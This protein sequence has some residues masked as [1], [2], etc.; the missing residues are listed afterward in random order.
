MINYI[1]DWLHAERPGK[2]QEHYE[3]AKALGA[4]IDI[5]AWRL[6]ITARKRTRILRKPPRPQSVP[7]PCGAYGEPATRSTRTRSRQDHHRPDYNYYNKNLRPTSPRRLRH[8]QPTTP[9][10]RN[11]KHGASNTTAWPTDKRNP[12]IIAA[13]MKY[14]HNKHEPKLKRGTIVDG[15]YSAVIAL[16]RYDTPDPVPV[17]K[18]AVVQMIK[19]VI[20]LETPPPKKR[21]P[22]NEPELQKLANIARLT[23]TYVPTRNFTAMCLARKGIMR[24]AE[25]A[26]LR[27][28]DVWIDTYKGEGVEEQEVAWI[29]VEKRKND[30]KREG[31][32]ILLG[33]GKHPGTCPIAWIKKFIK[34]RRQSAT[35]AFFHKP[36]QDTGYAKTSDW[37][38]GVLKKAL[39]AAKLPDGVW[40]AMS[41]RSGGATAVAAAGI[42]TYLLKRH[43][44]WKSNAVFNYIETSQ[45]NR[46]SVSQAF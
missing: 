37:L 38:N 27:A 29:F 26:A 36:N 15:A 33:A 16:Y 39:A 6:Y 35:A 14:L 19:K 20:V 5:Q 24:P 7:R 1:D 22:L 18:H 40:T 8:R 13:F 45:K 12:T 32:L 42:A 11:T 28:E 4:T 30:Q 3:C 43:G 21:I 34:L 17:A 44:G 46:L 23:H 41:L 10:K 2:A 25:V 31:H 9:T